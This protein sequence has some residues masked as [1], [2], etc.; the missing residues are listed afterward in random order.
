MPTYKR[1]AA[2]TRDEFVRCAPLGFGFYVVVPLP[3]VG[4]LYLPPIRSP[5][6]TFVSI[7]MEIFRFAVS[8]GEVGCR[9]VVDST[10]CYVHFYAFRNLYRTYILA[11]QNEVIAVLG[12]VQNYAGH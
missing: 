8:N 2:M 11:L 4:L 12:Q 1:I 7:S 9:S 6:F 5:F 3:T 10:L